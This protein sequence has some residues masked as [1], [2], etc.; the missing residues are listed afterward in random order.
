[1]K[2]LMFLLALSL[3]FTLPSSLLAQQIVTWYPVEKTSWGVVA[4]DA[5]TQLADGDPLPAPAIATLGY[6]V[7]AKNVVTNAIIPIA[8]NIPGTER[9]IVLPSRGSYVVGIEAQLIYVG[10][11]QP[12]VSSSISWSEVPAVCLNAATFGFKFQTGPKPSVG[13]RRKVGG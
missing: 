3:L 2:K 6:N 8:T 13:L 1:M 12:S 9:Q 5:V 4:W 7:Y 11:T 10:D